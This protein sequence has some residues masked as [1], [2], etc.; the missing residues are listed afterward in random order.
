MALPRW[1]IALSILWL[2]SVASACTSSPAQ[3][4][5]GVSPS[6]TGPAAG[7]SIYAKL[8]DEVRDDGTVSLDTALR[9]FSVAIAPL[10]GVEIEAGDVAPELYERASGSF[11]IR[12]IRDHIDELT[13]EQRAVVEA[14]LAPPPGE[15][16]VGVLAS[17][18]GQA[19][20]T[21]PLALGVTV[22]A[23]PEAPYE[24]ALRRADAG[25]SAS[26]GRTLGV[27]YIFN[28]N[29][30]PPTDRGEE[31]ATALAYAF[32][33]PRSSGEFD[34]WIYANPEMTD[35]LLSG[36]YGS[37]E[38]NA[39]MAHELFHC[40]QFDLLEKAGRPQTGP[41]WVIEGQAEWVG[42]AVGGPSGIGTG[43]WA[44]YLTSPDVLAFRRTYSAVGIYEHLAEIGRNPWQFLDAM[45]LAPSNEQA[46]MA[47][48]ADRE[49]F[50]DTWASGL[51]RRPDLGDAWNVQGRWGTTAQAPPKEIAIGNGSAEFL[52]A[53]G[54]LNRLVSVLASADITEINVDGH[55]RLVSGGIEF[56]DFPNVSLCT[57]GDGCMCPAGQ[58]YEGP[59]LTSVD[60]VI[61]VAVTGGLGESVGWIRGHSL[62]DFCFDDDEW[63]ACPNCA[64]TAGDP[65]LST[66]DGTIF[67]FQAAGEFTLLRSA[68]GTL[69]VQAR[70]EPM[71][72]AVTINTAFAIRSGA[73]R[74]T[75]VA[76][77][78]NPALLRVRLNG[79]LL[80]VNAPLDLATGAR[81]TPAQLGWQMDLPDGTRVWVAAFNLFVE[82]SPSLVETAS[83]VLAAVPDGSDLPALP[84]GSVLPRTDAADAHGRYVALYQ[85]FADAWRV[86]NETTLFDYDAG[87]STADYQQPGFPPEED[88][89]PGSRLSAEQLAS[90]EALCAGIDDNRLFQLCVYDVAVTGAGLFA[91]SYAQIL[92]VVDPRPDVRPTPQPTPSQGSTELPAGFVE[93]LNERATLQGQALG[94]DGRL[95]LSFEVADGGLL[96]AAN[97]ATGAIERSIRFN[98]GS[99]GQV[100]FAAGSLWVGDAARLP[101]ST[102][103]LARLDP[104]TLSV[105]EV[106]PTICPYSRTMIAGTDEGLWYYD[107]DTAGIAVLRLLGDSATQT[108]RSVSLPS[109]GALLVS[110]RSTVFFLGDN[111]P[112]RL[113][114]G[115]PAFQPM[116]SAAGLSFP[117]GGGS[118]TQRA[119]SAL[120]Y[121]SGDA[122]LM[123]VPLAGDLMAADADA[124][125]GAGTADAAAPTSLWRYPVD[126]SAGQQIAAGVTFSARGDEWRLGYGRNDPE[127]G[128][129][130]VGDGGVVKLW[131]LFTRDPDW[132]PFLMRYTALPSP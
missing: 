2:A 38:L 106:I 124:L 98:G 79:T 93:V 96:I 21:P 9:A 59:F 77:P 52:Q 84:D 118:W 20:L 68:D 90:A 82:P 36:E 61:S 110:S 33:W 31:V 85:T 76:E 75:F 28:I 123:T 24:E 43:W 3:Q 132:N 19:R 57:K 80:A 58:H 122:A 1:Q 35:R 86:T 102:C 120:Y 53:I 114:M 131:Q 8:F 62:D 39:T 101:I 69:E 10:P 34:C 66:I 72:T 48:Y 29:K 55:V 51:F 44:R 121:E 41:D 37:S 23:D 125:Y 13:A 67:D 5:P 81:L 49:D 40:Y 129:L 12:W 104:S 4:S 54:P 109:S 47:T 64:F 119:G 73:D 7:Q 11:A 60:N 46:F 14:V 111:G 26:L 130:L 88:G 116:S 108:V 56:V 30:S 27:S 15:S 89:A 100:A 25:I 70:Q 105:L 103:S 87:K 112:Y 107:H 42:E 18:G 17:L 83:G 50:L 97:P 99:A 32:L 65:H 117:V 6:P 95:Y 71:G 16:R 91:D 92:R 74:V 63:S 22:A 78:A 127:S 128:P 94:S 115:A 126:G 45:L 113:P